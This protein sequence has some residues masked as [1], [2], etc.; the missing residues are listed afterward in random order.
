LEKE[1]FTKSAVGNSFTLATISSETTTYGAWV[2]TFGY[3]SIIFA[4]RAVV[5][6]GKITAITIQEADL[7]N[8]SDVATSAAGNIL[9]APDELPLTA[10]AIFHAGSVSKKRYVRIGVTSL[11]NGGSTN[12]TLQGTYILSDSFAQP[13]NQYNTL[14]AAADLNA[15]G[16]L[17]DAK[18][19]FPKVS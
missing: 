7:S 3:N 9:Y 1:F 2:D 18:V 6:T 16:D 10:S 13:Y 5:T 19:T 17:A 4:M 8:Y 15:P 14:E 12:F 11:N